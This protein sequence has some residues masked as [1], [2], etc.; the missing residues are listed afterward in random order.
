MAT[1]DLAQSIRNWGGGPTTRLYQVDVS[2]G[3]PNGSVKYTLADTAD[4]LVL[5]TTGVSGST[6]LLFSLFDEIDLVG[7][8]KKNVI[9]DMSNPDDAFVSIN[10]G[11]GD[12]Y[13][14]AG[15]W[16]DLNG[17]AGN[18]TLVGGIDSVAVMSGGDG[19][20]T[21]YV[22]DAQF[23]DV[24]ESSSGQSSGGVDT[25]VALY[26]FTLGDNLEN[27]TLASTLHIIDGRD[28]T[29]AA[30]VGGGN[31]LNNIITGND[32]GDKLY[33]YGGDDTLIGGVGKDLLDGGDGT[34][35]AVFHVKRAEAY[36][37]RNAGDGSLTVWSAKEGV[38]TVKNVEKLQF[39]D[40]TV[41]VTA[42]SDVTLGNV[43]SNPLGSNVVVRSVAT[44]DFNGDGKSDILLEASPNS[45]SS[46]HGCYVYQM[47][48]LAMVN[49]GDGKVGW[50]PG[51]EWVARGTGNFNL[52]GKSDIL[53]QNTN[54]GSCYVW[55]MDGLQF[56]AGGYS[57]GFVG[58]TP[59]KDWQ[60]KG[61]GDFDADGVSDILLQNVK[62]GSCYVW[63]MNGTGFSLKTNG[64]GF[65]GWTPGKDWQVKGTGDFNGDGKSDILL[66]N[67]I[68]GSCYVWEMDGLSLKSGGNG[69]V[70]WAPGKDWQARGTGDYDGD[71]RSDI[72]LQNVTNGACY[73]WE[74]NGL[75][76]KT[77]GYGFVG[78]L[79]GPGDAWHAII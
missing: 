4:N 7:N 42:Q 38:D 64:Y 29:G 2:N 56:K 40:Q 53:L 77:D 54:D 18:D 14:V 48:G 46:Y 70:G 45:S 74:M 73:V 59:G 71:G 34:D 39:S 11:G 12:D 67:A 76:L 79:P 28:F 66:Q 62:D 44:S 32:L 35:I 61:T 8:S 68:D 16:T 25:V 22:F 31:S 51:P 37:V 20:D 10:G 69:F 26:D 15:S 41:N 47:N 65:V 63:E 3:L 17:D 33:G 30:R 27:L 60:V 57:Y 5:T 9:I 43:I 13:L 1:V 50:C 78:Y 36:I 24:S 52:D 72:L 6:N 21:Y 58:W 55:N 23:N 19:D 75:S 49:G